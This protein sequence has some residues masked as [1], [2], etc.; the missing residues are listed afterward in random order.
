VAR[1]LVVS[2]I[3]FV[4]V[5][6]SAQPLRLEEATNEARANG[7]DARLADLAV[8]QSRADVVAAGQLTNPAVLLQAGPSLG[9]FGDGCRDGSPAINAALSDQAALSQA[10]SGKL[11]LRVDAANLALKSRRAQRL[12]TSRQLIAAVKAQFITA[13]VAERSAAFTAEARDSATRTS[14]LFQARVKAGS[15]DEADMTRI[16]VQRLEA[17]QAVDAATQNVNAQRSVLAFLLG[18]KRGSELPDPAGD[19]WLSGR[20]LPAIDALTLN[21]LV[22]SARDARPDL[23]AQLEALEQAKTQG[24]LVRRQLVPDVALSVAFNSQGQAPTYSNPPNLMV[25]VSLPLPVLSQ[26]RGEIERADATVRLQEATVEQ[27]EGQIRTDVET[28]WSAFLASRQQVRRMEKG[29]LL[30]SAKRARELVSVQYD[31]GAASLL[32]LLDAQRTFVSV[33]IEYLTIIQAYWTS[34]FRLEAA[35]GRE[36]T[37]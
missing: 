26:L 6:T 36:F 20:P 13:L 14:E 30:A 27:V 37:S 19:E 34:V 31:K 32:E 28:A 16:E 11:G 17:E 23:L 15:I 7:F 35:V 1:A 21:E 8:E 24:A 9:C 25:G 3:V 33:N 29:G 5:S 18:R 2:L 4:G 10:L 22:A 12:D